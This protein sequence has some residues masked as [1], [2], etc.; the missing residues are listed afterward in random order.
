MLQSGLMKRQLSTLEEE[1]TEDEMSDVESDGMGSSQRSASFDEWEVDTEEELADVLPM[2]GLADEGTAQPVSD[3]KSN[4]HSGVMNRMSRRIQKS[5]LSL[6]Q[7]AK[8][9]K[10]HEVSRQLGHLSFLQLQSEE[11]P[12]QRQASPERRRGQMRGQIQAQRPADGDAPKAAQST[13]LLA[14][15]AALQDSKLLIA[16]NH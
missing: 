2:H 16:L 15:G 6:A 4:M 3:E 9:R 10:M 11:R 14:L 8:R 12:A 13:Q 5:L 7:E 1:S